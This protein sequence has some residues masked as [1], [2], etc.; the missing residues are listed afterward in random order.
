MIQ[1]IKIYYLKILLL[2]VSIS[3]TCFVIIESY[4]Y[5]SGYD[6]FNIYREIRI[7]LSSFIVGLIAAIF[8][9]RKWGKTGQNS[10]DSG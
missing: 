9:Y 10:P 1:T 6:N 7:L 4:N 8:H 3:I 2:A 5:F